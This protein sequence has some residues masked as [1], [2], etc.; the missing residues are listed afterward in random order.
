MYWTREMLDMWVP[1]RD[2]IFPSGDNA[3]AWLVDEQINKMKKLIG[4][5][6]SVPLQSQS[7]TEEQKCLLKMLAG[8]HGQTIKRMLEMKNANST[9]RGLPADNQ[10]KIET[11]KEAST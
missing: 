8:P 3:P 11:S 6:V 7:L 2:A 10:T 5:N 4:L 9:G 1:A